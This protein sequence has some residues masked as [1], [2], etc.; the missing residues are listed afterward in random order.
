MR[1]SV[2]VFGLLFYSP[3]VIVQ[4]VWCYDRMATNLSPTVTLLWALFALLGKISG[5]SSSCLSAV[6]HW[7]GGVQSVLH[8]LFWL[9]NSCL[10]LEA[11]SVNQNQN[12]QFIKPEI[13]ELKDNSQKIKSN[14]SLLVIHF[15]HTVL[16]W[17]AV[18]IS[19]TAAL[20]CCEN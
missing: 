6:W 18:K 13:N 19:M 16:L 4:V 7:A 8:S 2:V 20:N 14:C 17:Y 5:T 12:L 11:A 9:E 10:L 1:Q 15:T 3:A